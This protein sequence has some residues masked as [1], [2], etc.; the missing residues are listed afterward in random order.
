ML[1]TGARLALALGLRL[2][3][4]HSW[5]ISLPPHRGL[6]IFQLLGY[7]PGDS[8]E[9]GASA[10]VGM[11]FPKG[12]RCFR[13][14]HVRALSLLPCGAGTPLLLELWGAGGRAWGAWENSRNKHR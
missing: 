3:S 8:W 7:S 10:A 14:G 4:S 12:A 1:L 9:G 11:F 5:H 2:Q 13:Q 6:S